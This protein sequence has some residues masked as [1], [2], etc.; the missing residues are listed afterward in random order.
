MSSA[1]SRSIVVNDLARGFLTHPLLRVLESTIGWSLF[2]R[3]ARRTW[4]R[5]PDLASI[6]SQ[7]VAKTQCRLLL[8]RKGVA[9]P[10]YGSP[11]TKEL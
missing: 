11:E 4:R 9:T 8:S 3:G 6:A 2:A 7:R 10:A 1:Q 5:T